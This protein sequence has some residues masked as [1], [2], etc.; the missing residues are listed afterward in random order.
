MEG[1]KHWYESTTLQ[2]SIIS[3]LVLTVNIF[4][5]EVGTEEITHFITILFGLV[6]SVM[7]IYGRFNAT[8]VIK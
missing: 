5:W 1:S 8:R 3:A 4:K 7:T 6:G 2:G